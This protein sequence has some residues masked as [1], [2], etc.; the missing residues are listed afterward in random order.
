M[1]A[2]PHPGGGTIGGATPNPWEAL[3]SEW[4]SKWPLT[5]ELPTA[6]S[7]DSAMEMLAFNANQALT[8]QVGVA[9][10]LAHLAEEQYKAIAQTS[11][12]VLPAGPVRDAV[13]QTARLQARFAHRAAE[14]ATRFGRA[15]GHMAFA[16]PP[17]EFTPH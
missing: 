4:A 6:F 1:K 9:Y 11:T 3:V 2:Q 16:F 5:S 14:T 13:Q 12:E 7:P 8:C 10:A 17:A 15:F